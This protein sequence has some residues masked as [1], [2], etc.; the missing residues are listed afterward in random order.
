[1][2]A[3]NR[4][5]NRAVLLTVGLVLV[6]LGGAVAAAALVPSWL[7]VW[8][9]VAGG[10]DPT[11]DPSQA[12][13]LAIVLGGCLIVVVLLLVFIVR[14]GRGHTRT[15][16]QRGAS[17]GA[18]VVDTRV[19]A[20]LIEAALADHPD[21]ASVSVSGYRVR[22][23]PALK[24]AVSPRRGASPS[25]LR[26]EVDRVVERWDEVLGSEVPVLVTMA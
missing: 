24:I 25:E 5:L 2:N 22:G 21:V 23:V 4:A 14:Q 26:D 7:A 1:V 12:M 18:V 9:D 11:F 17:D 15:M 10:L 13:T 3:T 16:V 8:T 19:A 6:A 20:T